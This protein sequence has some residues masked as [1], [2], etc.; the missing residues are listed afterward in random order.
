LVASNVS[1]AMRNW[2]EMKEAFEMAYEENSRLA[3]MP[4]DTAHIP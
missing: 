1:D 3:K 2:E 4:I